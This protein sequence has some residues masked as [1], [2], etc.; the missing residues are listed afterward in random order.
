VAL[1]SVGLA[2]QPDND[3]EGDQT[4]QPLTAEIVQQSDQIFDDTAEKGD[5]GAEQDLNGNG[6]RDQ[7]DHNFGELPDPFAK[8]IQEIHR[9]LLMIKFPKKLRSGYKPEDNSS[10]KVNNK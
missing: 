7:H 3:A 2:E 5:I 10:E 9:V 8:R 1:A 4:D 6:Q